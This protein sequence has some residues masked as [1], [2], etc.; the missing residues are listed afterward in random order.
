MGLVAYC[1][2]I[3]R[4]HLKKANPE[5]DLFVA[6]NFLKHCHELGAGGAQ[7]ALGSLPREPARELFALIQEIGLY[8][9]A[10]VTAP[11]QKQDVERFN[12]EMATAKEAGAKAARTTIIP[13]RRYEFFDSLEM[14]HEYDALA[15]KSLELMTPIVE[16]HKVPLAV[17]NHKDHRDDERVALFK[18]ISSEYVGACVDTGNSFALLEDPISTIEKLAPWAHAVHLKD[19]A[20]KP[21]EEGFLLGD[22]P[23]GQGGLDLKRMVDI[24]KKTKPDIRF[25]LE[26]ITRDPLKVPCLTDKYWITFPHLPGKDLA[27][28][29]RYVRD[30][31][32]DNLQYITKMTPEE[33]LAREDAN[34]RESLAY[35]RD[36]LGLKG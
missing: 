36:E 10:I 31:Q 27:R 18:H 6:K 20:L 11:K 23:L 9:D 17:E 12:R 13:G 26:L 7:V 14:F 33:Q 28:A 24:L 5:F 21:Y 34:I 8:L 16:E 32:S 2:Q 35:A 25:T 30:H 15:K 22:I 19:Q 4:N 3:R 1:C 29:L